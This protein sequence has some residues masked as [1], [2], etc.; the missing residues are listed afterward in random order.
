MKAKISILYDHLYGDTDDEFQEWYDK[1]KNMTREELAK[2][3]DTTQTSSC[4]QD[5]AGDPVM[6][7]AMVYRRDCRR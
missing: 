3:A 1:V 7:V 2:T 4:K 6:S 5:T